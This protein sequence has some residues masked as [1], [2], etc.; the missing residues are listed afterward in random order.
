MTTISTA[1]RTEAPPARP[2]RRARRPAKAAPPV[3]TLFDPEAWAAATAKPGDY[4]NEVAAAH[5]EAFFPRLR[6]TKGRWSGQPFFLLAWQRSLI[7][8]IFGWKRADGTRRFRIVWCEVP[9]KNGKTALAAGVGL[10]LAFASGE[11]GAEVYC[12]ASVKK[13]ASIA[14]N[15]A[16]R[17]RGQSPKLRE[18]T[19]AFK[20]NLN[21]PDTFS[22]LEVIASD[23][24]TLDG[25]NLS[26]LIGDE[27]HA[28]RDREFYE[29]LHTAEGARAQPL[30]FLI[31]TAGTEL[32]TLGG[33]MHEHAERVRDG[34]IE[35]HGFLPCIFAA[36]KD[37]D[38]EAPAT[39]AKANPSM[40]STVRL[41]ALAE[42]AARARKLPRYLNAFKRYYLNIW[43]EQETI[44]LDIEKWRACSQGPETVTLEAL[45]GRACHAGLD[46]SS[47]TDLTALALLFPRVAAPGQN[48]PPGFDLWAHFWMPAEGLAERCRRDRV[49]YDQ[50]SEA[51]FITLTEGD[52]V[53]Y[54]VIRRQITGEAPGADA[55][56]L[57]KSRAAAIVNQVQLLAL[58]RDRWNA[59]QLTTQLMGDGVEIRDFGQGYA[60]MS[61]AS[62][63]F[64]KLVVEGTLNHGGNPVLDWMARVVSVKTDGADNIKPVK[65]DRRRS[66][67]RIDGIVATIMALGLACAEEPTIDINAL[68]L[69]RGGFA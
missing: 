19:N 15:E 58:A 56:F 48:S 38:W 24:G 53:D 41:D 62:K 67:K 29:V 37:D 33:E 57:A 23:Y 2:V 34:Q 64:E 54:D 1:L 7:R 32:A 59:T 39:W 28:W 30:E 3:A 50:W 44:W 10:Y 66:A 49:P 18:L 63:E 60:S 42:E 5:A 22:K 65:P 43:T 12:A 47:T 9:R 11:P 69:S 13:Q 36:D 51:G 40:G 20:F 4:F 35:D 45:R 61:A 14:F 8:A 27:V 52:V 55:E 16:L 21:R 6:H 17:M 26:G 46:L 31:T 25:L 68:I